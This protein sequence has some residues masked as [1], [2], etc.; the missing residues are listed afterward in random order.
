MPDKLGPVFLWRQRVIKF[1]STHGWIPRKPIYLATGLLL[2]AAVLMITVV[3]A[4]Q[5]S[6]PLASNAGKPPKSATAPVAAVPPLPQDTTTVPASQP[7]L[8]VPK[9][10]IKLGFGWQ[11]HPVFKDWRYHT[12]LDIAAGADQIVTALASGE[13][14]DVYQD[15]YSGLTAVV[16]GRNLTVYYGALA[17]TAVSKG[18]SVAAGSKIGTVGMSTA[19]PYPHL[20]LAVYKDNKYYDP[21]E[22]LK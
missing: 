13:V 17:S 21:R 7:V 1:I 16:K 12:G 15:R 6:P 10:E 2:T 4:I 8:A 3:S 22:L 20:H 14:S 5:L 9:G 18:D 19:E 11:E